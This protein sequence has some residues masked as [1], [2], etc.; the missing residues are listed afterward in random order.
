MSEQISQRK[1]NEE[2]PDEIPPAQSGVVRIGG[3]WSQ[4]HMRKIG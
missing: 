1:Q 4:L 3:A 2:E